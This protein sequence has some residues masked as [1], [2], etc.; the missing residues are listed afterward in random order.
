MQ[1][2]CKLLGGSQLSLRTLVLK[3][4]CSVSLF[5]S[6]STLKTKIKIRINNTKL[7]FGDVKSSKHMLS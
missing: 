4:L 6:T 1:F 2:C 7:T 5:R 3:C